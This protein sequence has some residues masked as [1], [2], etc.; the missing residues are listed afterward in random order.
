MIVG[1]ILIFIHTLVGFT[2]QSSL[3]MRAVYSFFLVITLIGYVYHKLI[4]R[5]R[6]ESDPYIHRKV[7]WDKKTEIVSAQDADW[8]LRLIKSNPSLYP[9]LQCGECTSVCLVSEV[10]RG[11]YN[12][13]RNLLYCLL[14]FKNL[15]LEGDDLVIWGCTVCH[16]CEEVCPQDIELTK[17]FSILKN[18]SF[19]QGKGPIYVYEQAK[20]IFENAQAISLQPAIER[21]RDE[22]ELPTIAKPDLNEVQTLLKNLGIEEKLKSREQ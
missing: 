18:Q 2:S 1:V 21:R 8:A 12:P 14:G 7:P 11:D 15:L 5:F 22:L 13:R 17:T 4:R 10:T 20:A 19:I 9:C 6:K 3:L 16:F